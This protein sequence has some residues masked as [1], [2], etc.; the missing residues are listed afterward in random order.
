MEAVTS[1][2]SI[3]RIIQ[4]SGAPTSALTLGLAL[5]V[6]ERC[7]EVLPYL[8]CWLWLGAVL[9]L[10]LPGFAWTATWA[11][12]PQWLALTLACLFLMQWAFAFGGQKCCFLNSYQIIERYRQGLLE[13]VRN[14]PIGVLRGRQVGHMADLLTDDINRV[15]AIF[16]HV[17]ADFVAAAGLALTTIL[18]LAAIEWRLALALAGLAPLAMLVLIASGRLFEQAVQRKHARFKATSGMLV[19]FIGG[20]A[21]LRLFNHSRAWSQQL[22]QAFTELKALSLG[23]EKWGGG[24]VMLFRLIVEC[25]LVVLF[26]AGGW[27]MFSHEY[28]A[29]VWL[30]FILLSYKFIGPLLELAEY[31]VMLRHACQSEM[32]LDELWRVP[33]LPE[34]AL[35]RRPDGLAVQFDRVSFAYGDRLVLRDVSFVVPPGSVT[36]VVGPSGAGKS[37]LLHLLARFHMPDSGAIRIGGLDLRDIGSDQLY[38]VVSMVFQQVQLFDG[39][40]ID[41]VRAGREQA[42]DEEVIQAAEAAHCDE[43]IARL[44]DGYQTKVGESGFG[45]SG[46]ERQRLSI[47]RALLKDAPLLLLDEV[48][49]SVDPRSQHAIQTSLGQLAAGRSVIMVAHRLNT[50]RHADQ[51]L[52]LDQG[53]LVKAGTHQSLLARNGLYAAMWRAQTSNG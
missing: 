15:E 20:L 32:K 33:L 16:A 45:L 25:G 46:G 53:A 27:S 31:L 36:A 42:S 2:T 3:R 40:I 30:A 39:S 38:R 50:I 22:D 11:A 28:P 1:W 19:E 13:R 52:V 35:A 6:L 24:P 4:R 48:T 37:T 7:S 17:L 14:M 9:P 49:A 47:A 18:L 23:I 21:T 29:L 43:F 26:I 12:S 10:S 8:L 51:I 41:N 44:A 5:R 34:P